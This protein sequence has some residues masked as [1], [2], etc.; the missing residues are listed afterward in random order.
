M[1][2]TWG[3]TIAI[4]IGL[5]VIY[6]LTYF[7]LRY[8]S[9]NQWF[10]PAGL[11]A[12]CLLFLP[13]RYWPFLLIGEIGLTLSQ[14]IEMTSVYGFPWVI[15]SSILLAPLTSIAPLFVRMNLRSK[16]ATAH[17]LPLAT[18]FMALWTSITKTL[19]N[20]LFSGPR[21]PEDLKAF[22]GFLIGD[23]LGILTI[24]LFVLL[25]H[26]FI[27][28]RRAHRNFFMNVGASTSAIGILYV[29]IETSLS[30][31]NFLQL[32]LLM[33]MTLPAVPLTY[34]HGWKGAAIGSLLANIGIAQ[35]ITYT[36]IQNTHDEVALY[37]QLGLTVS[38]T[39]FLLLGGKIT[40]HYD[41]ARISGFAEQEAV[42]HARMSML[43]NE[44]VVRDQLICMAQLQVLM[45]DERDQ[46][47]KTLRA[48]GKYHEAME[49][50]KRGVEHRQ[51]FEM[52]ALVLYPIGIERH[53][54]FGVLD[55]S[56]FRESRASGADVHMEFGLVDPRSLSEEMQVLAYRCLCNAIDHLSDWEP[57]QYR[58][59]LRTWHGRQRRGI[60]ISAEIVTQYERQATP[61]GE[62]ASLLLDARVWLNGGVQH[63]NSHSIRLL[64]S[65]PNGE[66]AVIKIPFEPE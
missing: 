49:L 29:L 61:H 32:T 53:G 24:L 20:Y 4:G 23:Y 65:E 45:D 43:S 3:K 33:M 1:G 19:L 11:R 10:L 27:Q 60:Y 62:S 31:N 30:G 14:K 17:W 50:N 37:A 51:L 18:L 39:I 5:A 40:K 34:F 52:Q 15:G 55:T 26:L 58:L 66:P 54:L 47:A 44:P 9:F 63:R 35:T 36:G 64:L 7:A 42:K 59:R 2:N 48:N 41:R 21:Q 46:L 38:S 13:Y 57:T 25:A 6:G 22:F 16:E 28:N 56:T 8:I 12:A